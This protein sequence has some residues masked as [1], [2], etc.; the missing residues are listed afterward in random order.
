MHR[1]ALFSRHLLLILAGPLQA[2]FALLIAQ[3]VLA[4]SSQEPLP[5]LGYNPATHRWG[6][7]S[8]TAE[9][10]EE[11]CAPGYAFV[12]ASFAGGRVASPEELMVFGNCC[13][14]PQD[15]LLEE[16]IYNAENCPEGSVATGIKLDS[17]NSNKP[18]LLLRC[19]NIDKK[20]YTLGEPQAGVHVGWAREFML[21]LG[22]SLLGSSEKQ[23]ARSA[24]PIGIRYAIGR[25]EEFRWDSGSCVGDIPGSLLTEKHAKFCKDL[26]FRSL[27]RILPN[28]SP[29][30]TTI[31]TVAVSM[32]PACNALTSVTDPAARCAE[33]Q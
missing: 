4:D 13:K 24:L 20:R 32:Y 27:L 6:A 11:N 1:T 16:H 23:I 5:C 17:A 18:A 8:L 22:L 3:T 12:G 7:E 30:D 26:R 29:G 9:A 2:I 19:T 25:R 14:L 10:A 31:S 21:H 33:I 28:T 15:A